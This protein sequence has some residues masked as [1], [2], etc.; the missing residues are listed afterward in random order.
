MLQVHREDHGGDGAVVSSGHYPTLCQQPRSGSAH[1]P[2]AELQQTGAR[3]AKPPAPL[4]VSPRPAS[5][6]KEGGF[7]EK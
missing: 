3:P 6:S 7:L 4:L 2:R 5:T 1:L